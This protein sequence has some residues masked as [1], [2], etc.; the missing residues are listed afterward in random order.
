[1]M[2]GSRCGA[3]SVCSERTLGAGGTTAAFRSGAV[4]E[5]LEETLGAGG[6]MES[7]VSPPRD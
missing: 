6:T 1:M 3:Y 2:L 7:S 4:L 5:L